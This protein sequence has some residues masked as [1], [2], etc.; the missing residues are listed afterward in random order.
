MSDAETTFEKGQECWDKVIQTNLRGAAL[1]ANSV[2]KRM[3]QGGMKGSII[4]IS[5]IVGTS[6]FVFPGMG[7]YASS[8]AALIALTKVCI[9]LKTSLN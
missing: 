4:N 5:S 7:I 8:K 9:Q 1:V 2:A 3:I 6:R